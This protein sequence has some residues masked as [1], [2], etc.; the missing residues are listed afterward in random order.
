LERGTEAGDE[1]VLLV[2][3]DEKGH[4]TGHSVGV[5]PMKMIIAQPASHER[6]SDSESTFFLWLAEIS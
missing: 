2:L 4:Q 1:A 6:K 3:V 5:I